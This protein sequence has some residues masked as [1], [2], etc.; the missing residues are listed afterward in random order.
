[1]SAGEIGV[2]IPARRV[3]RVKLNHGCADGFELLQWLS[4]SLTEERIAGLIV[5]ELF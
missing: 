3:H 4:P 2:V 5:V 1:M